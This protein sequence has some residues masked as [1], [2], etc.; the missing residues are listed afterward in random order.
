MTET[1]EQ[2]ASQIAELTFQLLANCQ[3]KEARLAESFG[4]SVSDFR[5]LRMFR[6]ETELHTKTLVE[7]V[8]VSNS[9]LTRILDE[10][11][12]K[13]FLTR[14]LDPADRRSMI[15]RLTPK[16]VALVEKLE[17]RYI[18]IHEEI[19]EGIP[20]ELHEPLLI[21]LQKLLKSLERWLRES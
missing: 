13:K 14:F 3:E 2:R 19:L 8:R 15:V 12:G 9:R 5:T 4:I 10:L 16:G 6:T 11:E 18:A 7:R 1:T 20:E 17:N 21:G